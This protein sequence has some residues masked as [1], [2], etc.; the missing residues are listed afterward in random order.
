MRFLLKITLIIPIMTLTACSGLNQ[1]PMKGQF[2]LN[3]NTGLLIIG[4]DIKGWSEEPK[5]TF[6]KHNMNIADRKLERITTTP[7]KSGYHHEYFVLKL[8]EGPWALKEI[9]RLVSSGFYY[10]KSTTTF[11]ERY[12]FDIKRNQATYFGEFSIQL[13]K[14]QSYLHS[15]LL[16]TR[17]ENNPEKAI[18]HLKG[19]PNVDTPFEISKPRIVKRHDRLKEMLESLGLPMQKNI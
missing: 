17:E 15:S 12:V 13:K 16:L 5:L 8:E 19:F 11:D 9:S 18:E 1:F 2:P 4:V 7:I 14:R 6:I 10:N 3:D